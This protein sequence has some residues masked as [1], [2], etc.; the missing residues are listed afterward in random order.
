[1]QKKSYGGG[2]GGINFGA[3]G[4]KFDI[5]LA[6]NTPVR[7]TIKV[8][9]NGTSVWTSP[10]SP[11]LT[12]FGAAQTWIDTIGG[13]GYF[14]SSGTWISGTAPDFKLPINALPTDEWL[15][16]IQEDV[17]GGNTLNSL[18]SYGYS[19]NGTAFG[20]LATDYISL[21]AMGGLITWANRLL[22]QQNIVP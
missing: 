7:W 13:G 21:L 19:T 8:W 2:I 18:V 12:S 15:V 16:V 5:A 10:Q 6:E 22:Q 3:Q 20:F 14:A 9:L 11:S 1:L 4:F 17:Q